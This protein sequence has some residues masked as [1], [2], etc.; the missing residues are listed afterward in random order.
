MGIPVEELELGSLATGITIIY[1]QDVGV[2][3][4]DTVLVAIDLIGVQHLET[5]GSTCILDE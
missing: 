4:I 5:Q 1:I 3:R 2:W